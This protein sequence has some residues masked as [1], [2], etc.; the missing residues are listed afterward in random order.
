MLVSASWAVTKAVKHTKRPSSQANEFQIYHYYVSANNFIITER[1]R[2]KKGNL[3]HPHIAGI[4]FHMRSE[5]PTR[6]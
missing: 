3:P 4:D 1:V 6:D 2:K 5:G